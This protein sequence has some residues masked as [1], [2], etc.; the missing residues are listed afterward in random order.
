MPIGSERCFGGVGE[1][2]NVDPKTYRVSVFGAAFQNPQSFAGI[3]LLCD[4]GVAGTVHRHALGNP[5]V[6]LAN[7]FRILAPQCSCAQHVLEVGARNHQ[8]RAGGVDG[9]VALVAEDKPVLGVIQYKSLIECVDRSTQDALALLQ[10]PMAHGEA[11]L[12]G[13]IHQYHQP[14]VTVD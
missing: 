3:R 14:L 12:V 5:G 9:S 8:V 7:R 2:S 1:G 13:A 11:A 10:F 6:D 4:G